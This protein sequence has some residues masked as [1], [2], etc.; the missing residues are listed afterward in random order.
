[1]TLHHTYLLYIVQLTGYDVIT[2]KLWL[3]L[4]IQLFC[5]DI[6]AN[7]QW[8]VQSCIYHSYWKELVTKRQ[9]LQHVAL[10]TVPTILVKVVRP[11]M[12]IPNTSH[13]H[14]IISVSICSYVNFSVYSNDESLFLLLPPPSPFPCSQPLPALSCLRWKLSPLLDPRSLPSQSVSR[15][16][17]EH[18]PPQM[19]YT[20]LHSSRPVHV[21]VAVGVLSCGACVYAWCNSCCICSELWLRYFV[22]FLVTS[23][24]VCKFTF[25]SAL[26]HN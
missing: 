11:I 8:Y 26:I 10:T 19:V 13:P 24:L 2:Q 21:C 3:H 14:T 12:R 18:Q 22:V 4:T 7:G 17:A 5:H 20:C 23:L 1:M 16:T 9:W 25:M 15:P 6:D